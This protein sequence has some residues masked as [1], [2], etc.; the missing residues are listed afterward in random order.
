MKNLLLGAGAAALLALTILFTVLA[1]VSATVPRKLD[2]IQADLDNH[3]M[4]LRREAIDQVN[5]TRSDILNLI[6]RQANG[7][8]GDLARQVDGIRELTDRRLGDTLIRVDTALGKVDGVIALAGDLHQEIKPALAHA[9]SITAHAD[10]AS[11]I[12]L[13][14]DALPAQIL[15]LT[16]AAKVTL[17]ETAQTMK[18][19][20]DA[21]PGFVHD[22][23][24]I[25]A[26]VAGITDDAHQLTSKFTAPKTLPQKIWGGIQTAAIVAI[27]FF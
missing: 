4:F 24:A 12:L 10:E 21:T 11:D 16:A 19:V 26:N 13:R 14:R 5:I 8:R 15:G 3:M 7:V 25:V 17:G 6:E 2:A 27:R 22:G 1:A 9:A 20:R 23:E 18:T